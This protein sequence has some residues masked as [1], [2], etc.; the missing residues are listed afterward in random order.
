MSVDPNSVTIKPGQGFRVGVPQGGKVV[1]ELD[2]YRLALSKME[3]QW[4]HATKLLNEN[5]LHQ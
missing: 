3:A 4:A 5:A 2:R 1:S